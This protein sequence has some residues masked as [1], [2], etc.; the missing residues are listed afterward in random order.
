MFFNLETDY[1]IRIVHCIAKKNERI[2]ARTISE[3]TGVTLRFSLKILR[4]LVEA[5]ILKSYKGAQGGYVL[6]RPASEI[7]L[8]DVIETMSGQ[9][10]FSR[11]QTDEI[12]CT[13]PEGICCFRNVF[14]QLTKIIV[15]KLDKVTFETK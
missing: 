8:L 3:E 14:D 10:I 7:S 15:D 5:G 4:K 2:D 13:H 11:C 12:E 6:S 1:A 9:P